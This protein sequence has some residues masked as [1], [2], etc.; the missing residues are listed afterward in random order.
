MNLY[1]CESRMH[2]DAHVCCSVSGVKMMHFTFN[3]ICLVESS[4]LSSSQSSQSMPL[5]AATACAILTP[6]SAGCCCPLNYLH[7]PHAVSPTIHLLPSHICLFLSLAQSFALRHL[8]GFTSRSQNCLSQTES[9][10]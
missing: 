7:L 9:L 5:F 6:L 1:H 4:L 3:F 10:S 2:V 8:R